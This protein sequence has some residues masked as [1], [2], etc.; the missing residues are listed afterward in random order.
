MT[1]GSI[2]KG[3]TFAAGGSFSIMGSGQNGVPGGTLFAG[4]F[5]QPTTWKVTV[6]GGIYHYTL[7]GTIAG[8]WGG[9]LVNG[10]VTLNLAGPANC[11]SCLHFVGG[12]VNI[13]L[14][15]PEPGTL[16]LLGAGVVGLAGVVRRRAV[17]V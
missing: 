2:L 13:A 11:R 5:T 3:A 16:S 12:D 15:V 17:H 1:S 10:T 9:K 6:S 14:P 4:K 8:M 7:S